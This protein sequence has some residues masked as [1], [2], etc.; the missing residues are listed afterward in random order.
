MSR[1]GRTDRF[2]HDVNNPAE[3]SSL[4]AA[5]AILA[6]GDDAAPALRLYADARRETIARGE[7]RR[8]VR[9]AATVFAEHG[10]AEEQRVL[11]VLPDSPEYV[12]AFLGAIWNGSVPVLVNC[13]LR[14]EQYS[15]FVEETRAR[16]V[17]TTPEIAAAVRSAPSRRNPPA[18]LTVASDGSGSFTDALRDAS[19]VAE[20]YATHAEDAALWLYSSG[21]TGRPK[22]VVH[23]HRGMMHAVASYGCA[24]LATR[25]DDVA[26]ATSKLFFAYGLGASLYFPLAVGAATVLAPDPFDPARSWRILAEERP[27]LF[28]SVPSAYRALLQHAPAEAPEL[29]GGV[30]RFVSAGEGLPPALFT[31]WKERFGVEIVDGIGST[32]ALHIFLS[33][34]PGAC[35]PGTLGRAVPGYEV[36]IVDAAGAAVQR[37]TPGALRVRGDSVAAGYW[38]REEATQSAFAA[39]WFATG[40]QAVE[41]ED[42]TIRVLGRV[43]DLFKVSG[44]WVSPLDVEAIIAAVPGVSECGVV[45]IEGEEGLIGAVAFAVAATTGAALDDLQARIVA[46]CAQSL[47]RFKRPKRI[48]FLEALPRTATGKLQRYVL[49]QETGTGN[50]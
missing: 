43:D 48:V 47:P 15:R 7:L 33:N 4:N 36:E 19:E 23:L 32:E 13:F 28:F 38:H 26:Y 20:P 27:T 11:L 35:V 9:K 45:G 16:A 8:R 21:T 3:S 42:G 41:N 18:I 24:I 17:V 34:R 29:L 14:P 1:R 22:G 5:A 37:G 44:Q 12:Y 31:A 30:R 40:D 25:A 2:D 50:Q 6:A 46:A 10:V 49:R 39:G